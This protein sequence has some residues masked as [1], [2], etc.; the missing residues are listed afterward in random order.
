MNKQNLTIIYFF[1]EF[2]D[3]DKLLLKLNDNNYCYIDLNKSEKKIFSIVSQWL[4]YN[5]L[6]SNYIDDILDIW[7]CNGMEKA[8]SKYYNTKF[9]NK[10]F[11]E[12]YTKKCSILDYKEVYNDNLYNQH[13][14]YYDR[15]SYSIRA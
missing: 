15:K 13:L 3:C 6:P 10:N 5:S 12:R 11:Y 1:N 8:F 4:D 9:I 7:A 14:K 2:E